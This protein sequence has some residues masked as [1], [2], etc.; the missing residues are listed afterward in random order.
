MFLGIVKTFQHVRTALPV[1][2]PCETFGSHCM[3]RDTIESMHTGT[4][5]GRQS[6]STV[7][8]CDQKLIQ[9]KNYATSA[10]VFCLKILRD[11]LEFYCHQMHAKPRARLGTT[12]RPLDNRFMV[13]QESGMFYPREELARR[14]S[15]YRLISWYCLVNKASLLRDNLI[16][17]RTSGW[18][19]LRD[20]EL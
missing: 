3:E 1:C 17:G 10:S 13:L 20:G 2:N 15:Q 19:L 6:K 14:I 16:G 4:T 7:V 9:S 5:K 8:G 18:A 11:L 12:A